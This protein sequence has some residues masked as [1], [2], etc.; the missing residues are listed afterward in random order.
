[1][2]VSVTT[3]AECGIFMFTQAISK[4]GGKMSDWKK[5]LNQFFKEKQEKSK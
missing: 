4:I 3:F 5:D 2:S 1:M